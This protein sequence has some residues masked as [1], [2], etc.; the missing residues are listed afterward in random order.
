MNESGEASIGKLL[1]QARQVKGLTTAEVAD[2]LKLTSR[3]IE[4]LEAEEYDKLPAAVFVRGFIRNYARLVGL[5]ADRLIEA[6]GDTQGAT[7]TIT[8]H[9]EGVTISPSPV[10]RWMFYLLGS[11][12]LFMALVAVLYQWLSSGEEAFVEQPTTP[13]AQSTQ[14]PAT[15]A[16]ATPAAPSVSA[17]ASPAVATPPSQVP[18]ATPTSAPTAVPAPSTA[19]AT[20]PNA[21]AKPAVAPIGSTAPAA[22]LPAAPTTPSVALM[23]ATR[24]TTPPAPTAPMLAPTPRVSTPATASAAVPHAQPAAAPSA[25][26]YLAPPAHAPA[27]SVDAA[28]KSAPTAAPGGSVLRFVAVEESWVQVVDGAGKR[29]SQLIARGASASIAGTPPFRIVVGNAASVSLR[30]NDQHIDLRPFT[31]DKVAR[32][33]LE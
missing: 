12:I 8:A 19:P 20:S 10:K 26:P 13:S 6:M 33:S 17:P 21:P 32:L 14:A 31:G 25:N 4:A 18:V 15:Q 2:K 3:Q 5:D 22:T 11:F 27:M 28:P 29:S 16:P 23:P 24:P 30:Y 1:S 9:S 7:A